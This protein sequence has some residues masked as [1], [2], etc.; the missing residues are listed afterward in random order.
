[1]LHLPALGISAVGGGCRSIHAAQLELLKLSWLAT[2]KRRLQSVRE[3]K[4]PADEKPDQAS[5]AREESQGT[6]DTLDDITV[7]YRLA[8]GAEDRYDCNGLGQEQKAGQG[9]SSYDNKGDK[10]SCAIWLGLGL[11][12]GLTA[13]LG[14][15]QGAGLVGMYRAATCDHLWVLHDPNASD[16]CG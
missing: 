15:A 10:S 13:V 16:A 5:D 3:D 4:P 12:L 14:K 11:G 8:R 6:E 1:M 2:S 7:T 9:E